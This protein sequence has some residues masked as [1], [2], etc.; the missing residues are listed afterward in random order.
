MEEDKREL[1]VVHEQDLENV[2]RK[3]NLW[4]ELQARHLKCK[5]CGTTIT[6]DNLHSI[7]P[8]AE[9]F[10]LTCDSAECVQELSRYMREKNRGETREI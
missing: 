10:S 4:E 5:F 2:M 6:S 9:G 3:A 8:Q 7:F 1:D